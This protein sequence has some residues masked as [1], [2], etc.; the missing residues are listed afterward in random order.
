MKYLSYVTID[1]HIVVY[2]LNCT[3]QD[4]QSYSCQNRR[5]LAIVIMI[6]GNIRFCAL[7]STCNFILFLGGAS[8]F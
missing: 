1:L 8:L 4:S 3:S 6:G 7:M 2:I 5:P